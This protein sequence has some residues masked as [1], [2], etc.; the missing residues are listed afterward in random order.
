MSPS[1]IFSNIIFARLSHQ[2]FFGF[3]K[4]ITILLPSTMWTYLTLFITR[5][6]C[7]SDVLL[8]HQ[9][10]FSTRRL[11]NILETG[12]EGL[13]QITRF[14]HDKEEFRV[15]V[16]ALCLGEVEEGEE[17]RE[18]RCSHVFHQLCLERWIRFKH[19]IMSPL[20]WLSSSAAKRGRRRGSGFR[21]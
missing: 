6:K 3:I 10:S 9:F 12:P 17:I 19:T 15:N 4:L 11:H 2:N 20:S 5:I 16:C 7:A 8:Y 1:Q 14:K 13:I 18:L 21:S